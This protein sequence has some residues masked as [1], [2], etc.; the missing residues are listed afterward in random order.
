MEKNRKKEDNNQT[1]INIK[2]KTVALGVTS[3]IFDACLPHFQHL[4]VIV[5]SILWLLEP[6][7][8]TSRAGGSATE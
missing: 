8:C 7:C 5:K 3:P 2:M 1:K 6:C 4:H